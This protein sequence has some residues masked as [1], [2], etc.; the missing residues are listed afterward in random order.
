MADRFDRQSS[1]ETYG[2]S[3]ARA[4]EPQRSPSLLFGQNLFRFFG[5]SI[6]L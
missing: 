3:T 5:H 1:T 6:L 2:G 4:N